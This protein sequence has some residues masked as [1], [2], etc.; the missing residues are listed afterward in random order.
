MRKT[1][2]AKYVKL[3]IDRKRHWRRIRSK[4]LD[5]NLSRKERK[6]KRQQQ[7]VGHW[8]AEVKAPPKISLYTQADHERTVIFLQALRFQVAR[9]SRVRICFRDTRQITA[10]GGLLFIAELDRLVKAYPA[11]RFSCIRPPLQ[12][13]HQYG[14][15]SRLTESVLNQIGFFKLVNIRERSLPAYPSVSCWNHSQG[16]VAEGAIAGKLLN[17]VDG[18]LSARAK[19]RLYRGA[20]EAISN[21]VD[22]AYPYARQDGLGIVDRRWWMFVGIKMGMLTICVCDLGVGIPA[23]IPQKHPIERIKS[24][25]ERLNFKGSSDSEWIQVSTLISKSRTEKSYRGKGGKDIRELLQHYNG[26]HLSIFSN[27][28]LFRDYNKTTRTRGLVPMA[29]LDEQRRSIQGTVIE[30]TVPLEELS[31]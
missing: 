11:V 14:N 1:A 20:I 4:V 19:K 16:V 21:C 27:K 12:H 17:H 26:A 30:W 5:R 31:V 15:E 29:I 2:T 24:V 10:A 9:N 13:D 25:L 3:N 8:Q 7:R 22:H 28:G 23:T 18:Q 6:K